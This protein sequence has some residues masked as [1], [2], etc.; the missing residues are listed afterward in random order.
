MSRPG[1]KPRHVEVVAIIGT[2]P[3][4]GLAAFA[5]LLHAREQRRAKP[6]LTIVSPKPAKL[7]GQ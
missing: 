1:R 4:A 2:P 7:P 6:A 5:A 3:D